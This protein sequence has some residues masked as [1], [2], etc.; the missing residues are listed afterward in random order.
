MP[1]QT[2]Y[3]LRQSVRQQI[4]ALIEE[5]LQTG[6][7]Q[8]PA[9]VVLAQKLG[10][11]RSTIREVLSVLAGEGWI[12][13]R[14]GCGTYINPTLAQLKTPLTPMPYFWDIIAGCGKTPSI[15]FV[16]YTILEHPPQCTGHLQLP[17]GRDIARLKL[18]YCAD[19]QICIVCYDYFDAGLINRETFTPMKQCSIFQML[20]ETS[21]CVVVWANTMLSASD[22]RRMPEAGRLMQVAPE[23]FK[24]LLLVKNICYDTKDQPILYSECLFDTDLVEFGY[25][26]Q[27]GTGRKRDTCEYPAN[28]AL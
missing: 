1:E 20:Y 6:D 22:T 28:P 17:P 7:R 12:I 18:A 9:E 16:D 5:Q 24:P 13:R 26:Q 8:M 14:H 10:V 4:C 11:S 2:G 15:R 19:G 27:Y 21:G 25:V 23:D 3:N